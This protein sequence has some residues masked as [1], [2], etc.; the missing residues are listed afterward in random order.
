M[1]HASQLVGVLSASVKP[2]VQSPHC[3]LEVTVGWTVTYSPG[4]QVVRVAQT[5]SVVSV[6]LALCGV[7]AGAGQVRAEPVSPC[8]TARW[9]AGDEKRSGRV[10]G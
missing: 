1:S 5:V 2:V 7:Q 10:G 3:R 9:R 4:G 8:G 6:K